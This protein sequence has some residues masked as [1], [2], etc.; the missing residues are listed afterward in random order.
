MSEPVPAGEPLFDSHAED[1]DAECMQ[2]LKASG[3]S[4]EFFARG[5]VDALRRWWTRDGRPEPARILDYGCGLGDVG[6]LLAAAFPGAQV[7][8]LDPSPRLVEQARRRHGDSGIGFGVL[9]PGAAA[10]PADLV[11]L[12]GVVHHVEPAARPEL[13][14]ALAGSLRPGGVLAVFENNPLNPGTRYVMSRIPF[15][16]DAVP[17]TA[18]ALR[19][20]LRA[21]GLAPL[22]TEN[23]FWFP[24]AL[25][26][27]RPLERGLVR[28]PLGAQY[29]VFAVRG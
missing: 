19:R 24:R 14:T 12:N 18:V 16:R 15:D 10:E 22:R 9:E 17:L 2:G 28:V 5:R 4:R 25:A 20:H 11:H 8:G 23:L 3:E 1:Y 29:G 27:L 7:V 26:W 21:A 13:F 6:P